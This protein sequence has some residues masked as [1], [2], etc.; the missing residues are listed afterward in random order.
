MRFFERHK[1]NL[2]PASQMRLQRGSA[3]R[4]LDSKEVVDQQFVAEAPKL[5]QYM[6]DP[7]SVLVANDNLVNRRFAVA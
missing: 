2:S 3:M 6:S 7:R 5:Y 1:A 4:I